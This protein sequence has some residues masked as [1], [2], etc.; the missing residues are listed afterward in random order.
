MAQRGPDAALPIYDHDDLASCF[1]KLML[2]LRQGLS[3]VMEDNA[4][5]LPLIE[6]SHGLN[7]ATVPESSMVRDFGFVLAVKASVPV[8]FC[9]RTSRRR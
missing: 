7:I 4:I 3:Q 1:G 6:R 9:K 8:M 5:Q 2:L